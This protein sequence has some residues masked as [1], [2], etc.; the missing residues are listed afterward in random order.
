M[1]P[2]R[3]RIRVVASA[4][5]VC[6]ADQAVKALVVAAIPASASVPIIPGIFS[7]THVE[8]TGVAFGLL[9]GASPLVTVLAA[10]T[11]VFLL[12]YNKGRQIGTGAAWPGIA[13]M[14]G[15]A[16]G[17]LIDRV[18]LGYVVDYLDVHVWPVFNLADIAIVLGAAVLII[19]F[20]REGRS[21]SRR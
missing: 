18:R 19:A 8:N 9:A 13:A 11:L 2:G 17:N 7:L 5:L 10:L 16:A 20:S 12:F 21:A 14:A 15:G 6:A 4:L 3:L 1:A